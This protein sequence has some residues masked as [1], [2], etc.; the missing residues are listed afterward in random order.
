M[1]LQTKNNDLVKDGTLYR[2][3]SL[4]YLIPDRFTMKNSDWTDFLHKVCDFSTIDQFWEVLN[5]YEK[6]SSLPKGCRYYVFKRG[7]KPLWEDPSNSGG[8]ELSIE[9]QI[10]HS[11]K[12][13]INDRWE[14]IL[15][16]L[17]GEILPHSELINGVEF[18][19]RAETFRIKLWI[20]PC[21]KEIIPEISSEFSR[22]VKWKS[23]VQVTDIKH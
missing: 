15:M 16:A 5:S 23:S 12:Q 21:N 10:S 22:I 8:F 2:N 13:K 9:H 1:N 4:W 6:A 11:K 17:I 7:V 18:T 3:W 19:I 14:D 20:A